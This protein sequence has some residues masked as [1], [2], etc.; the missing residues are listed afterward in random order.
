M[1][2]PGGFHSFEHRWALADAFDWQLTIGKTRVE[3]YTRT[4]SK[5]LKDGLKS[6]AHVRLLTPVEVSLSSGINIFTVNGQD[7]EETVK[8]LLAKNITASVTPYR[9]LYARLT[10]SLVNNEAEV[11]EV[12]KAVETIV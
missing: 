9:A 8:R 3:E 12:L 4:L 1:C 6:M 7:P 11:D 5:R 2:T 10:P